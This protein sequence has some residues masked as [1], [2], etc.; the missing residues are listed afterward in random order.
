[1]PSL[2]PPKSRRTPS[3][4][5]RAKKPPVLGRLSAALARVKAGLKKD[6]HLTVKA[7]ATVIGAHCNVSSSSLATSMYRSKIRNGQAP[8]HHGNQALA[9][10]EEDRPLVLV[11]AFDTAPILLRNEQV[12]DAVHK[13]LKD[14]APQAEFAGSESGTPSSSAPPTPRAPKPPG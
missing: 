11:L 14:R 3:K 13:G 2:A 10:R 4:P 1:M 9:K 12:L 8:L 7:A 6:F 5:S